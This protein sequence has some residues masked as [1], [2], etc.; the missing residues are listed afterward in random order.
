M[1]E[2]SDVYSLARA[3]RSAINRRSTSGSSAVPHYLNVDAASFFLLALYT[4]LES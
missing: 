3:S 2:S 1:E 4:Y